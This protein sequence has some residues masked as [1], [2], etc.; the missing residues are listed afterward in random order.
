MPIFRDFSPFLRAYANYSSS[1]TKLPLQI[2]LIT[3]NDRKWLRDAFLNLLEYLDEFGHDIPPCQENADWFVDEVFLPAALRQEPV[4]MAC[5]EGKP[6]GALFWCIPTGTPPVRV[7][8]AVGYGTYVDPDWRRQGIGEAL[9]A[10]GLAMLSALEV[11]ELIGVTYEDNQPAM[12]FIKRSG[13]DHSARLV[14]INLHQVDFTE[15][16]K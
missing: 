4:L 8:Q 5:H 1:M 15:S 10:K 13:I 2:R 12:N 6:V 3:E 14:R 7:K 16:E 9:W 11:D